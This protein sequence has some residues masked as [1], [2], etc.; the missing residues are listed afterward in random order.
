MTAKKYNKLIKEYSENMLKFELEEIETT[1]IY[2]YD[3]LKF[4]EED[5][6]I[7]NKITKNIEKGELKKQIILDE[8]KRRVQ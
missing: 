3:D 6:C 7:R 5:S 4:E 8:I 2:L 1:I